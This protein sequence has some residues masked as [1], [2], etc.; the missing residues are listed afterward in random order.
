MNGER[1][2]TDEPVEELAEDAAAENPDPQTRR[3]SFEL[4]LMDEDRSEEGEHV[5]VEA[6]AEQSDR[7]GPGAA[8]RAAPRDPGTR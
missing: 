3:E 5:E 1:T 4:E 2:R 6:V 8:D 7:T